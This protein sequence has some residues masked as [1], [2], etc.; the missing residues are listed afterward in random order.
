MPA[1]PSPTLTV[2]VVA[3]ES[4]HVLPRSLG[5]LRAGAE[6]SGVDVRLVVVDN[7]STDGSAEAAEAA[8]PGSTVIRN[9][10]NRGYGP[11][12]N[13]AV[14]AGGDTDWLLF[15]NPDTIV[16]PGLMPL[17]P[18]V[19][20]LDAV[21]VFTPLLVDEGR[22]PVRTAY[23]WPT[24][25][26]EV[27]RLT[28]V[29]AAADRLGRSPASVPEG[30]RVQLGEPV[31]EA[32][33]VDYPVGAC[34]FV[35]GETWRRVGPFDEGFVLYHEEMEWC[36]RAAELGI[37]SHVIPRGRAIHLERA[38][39]RQRPPEVV[40]WQYRG[41]LRFYELHRPAAQRRALRAAMAASF[42]ARA[43]GARLAGRRRGSGVLWEVARRA[44][45]R[46]R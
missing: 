36:W 20:R 24:L 39:S 27:A 1:T 2:C 10:E 26:K 23:R 43:A 38:S 9:S 18:H 13:R 42:A 7:A 14:E 3:F 11:A 16:E 4:A 22:R 34:L 28:G 32:V 46:P 8:W 35:R 45:A 25:A 30:E 29:V 31:G 19:S 33:V 5:A 6:G 21:R 44:G 37:R 17:L 12:I 40:L 41:L 15:L